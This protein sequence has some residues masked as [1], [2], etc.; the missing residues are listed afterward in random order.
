MIRE[1]GMAPD[2]ASERTVGVRLRGGVVLSAVGGG[3][4]R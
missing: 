2:K 3:E 1:V 4:S